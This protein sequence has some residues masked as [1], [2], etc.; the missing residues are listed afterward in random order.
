MVR[1]KLNKFEHVF[2]GQCVVTPRGSLYGEATNGIMTNGHMET[3][4]YIHD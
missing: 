3:H 4:T 1:S 2:G